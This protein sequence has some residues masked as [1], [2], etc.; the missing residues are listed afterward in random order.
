MSTSAWQPLLLL[1]LAAAPLALAS[2]QCLFYSQASI[3]YTSS[4][5]GSRAGK[6]VIKNSRY[7]AASPTIAGRYYAPDESNGRVYAI[8]VTSKGASMAAHGSFDIPQPLDMAVAKNGLT[9]VSTSLSVQPVMLNA[10][11]ALLLSPPVMLGQ[12][13]VGRVAVVASNSNSARFVV[14]CRA[15][16]DSR[17]SSDC[18]VFF[19]QVSESGLQ[20]TG[21]VTL[22]AAHSSVRQLAVVKRSGKTIV[23]LVG[24]GGIAVIDATTAGSPRLLSTTS[25][26]TLQY[27]GV[28]YISAIDSLLVTSCQDSS[29][30]V[31]SAPTNSKAPVLATVDPQT[32]GRGNGLGAAAF[33]KS[34]GLAAETA[35]LILASLTNAA[36]PDVVGCWSPKSG[37]DVLAT[38]FD[39]PTQLAVVVQADG[40]QAVQMT[41]KNM[42]PGG[43]TLPEVIGIG[44]AVVVLLVVVIVLY[45]KR[46]KGSGDGAYGLLDEE[47]SAAGGKKDSGLV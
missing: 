29:P 11:S 14:G 5:V 42:L 44:V 40:V 31:Y 37:G 19:A 24:D 7:L 12:A 20:Q 17:T 41:A 25:K 35:V 9:L 27:C 18:V 38:L 1:L 13:G 8:D 15:A 43:L 45:N 26:Q 23:Y 28:A 3:S 32:T 34:M 21:N 16:L 2:N 39:S 10:T 6:G 33:S 4:V 22:P 46:R 36:S 30:L 47:V